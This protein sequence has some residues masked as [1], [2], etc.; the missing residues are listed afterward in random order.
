MCVIGQSG[1]R[2]QHDELQKLREKITELQTQ[3]DSTEKTNYQ[4]KQAVKDSKEGKL[5]FSDL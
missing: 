1:I 4:L 3:C 2:G 5:K